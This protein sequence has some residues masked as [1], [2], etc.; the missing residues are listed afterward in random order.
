[1]STTILDQSRSHGTWSPIG[2]KGDD[3]FTIHIPAGQ[4][5]AGCT[6]TMTGKRLSAGTSI[7]A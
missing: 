7:A 2:A 4:S 5:F 1:M 3:R 6:L